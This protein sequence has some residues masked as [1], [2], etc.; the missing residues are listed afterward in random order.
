MPA[1][2][3][4]SI[5]KRVTEIV[6]QALRR[7]RSAGDLGADPPGVSVELPKRA[8]QGDYAT[9]VA[10]TLAPLERRP[11]IQIAE[12]VKRHID[13]TDLVASVE[14]AGPGYVNLTVRQEA[15]RD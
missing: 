6:D 10:M 8:G 5:K 2:V 9:T 15:W 13:T 1:T 4:L 11:P 3:A 12:I 7:A 14:I